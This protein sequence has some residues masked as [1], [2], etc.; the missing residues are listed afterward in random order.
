MEV[1]HQPRVAATR[2]SGPGLG[3]Q[4]SADLVDAQPL[5][6]VD[7]TKRAQYLPRAFEV[8][9]R[10]D[11]VHVG[12]STVLGGG[13][14]RAGEGGALEQQGVHTGR[15]EGVER[16]DSRGVEPAQ[17]GAGGDAAC[18]LLQRAARLEG[19]LARARSICPGLGRHW[20]L[21]SLC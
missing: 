8:A 21:G 4:A 18:E 12:I 17:G 14:Q 6:Q 15:V 9:R 5:G 2:D 11:H 3:V 1:D 10:D 13:I 16:L 20:W 19:P 7:V